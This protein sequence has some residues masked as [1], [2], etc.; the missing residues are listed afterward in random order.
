M[1]PQHRADACPQRSS[2]VHCWR[3]SYATGCPQP[4]RRTVARG[5]GVMV[6]LRDTDDALID[7]EVVER[8]LGEM[9]GA[10]A[11]ALAAASK[12]FLSGDRAVA[13]EIVAG[14]QH[15]D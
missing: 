10:V 1:A 13:R 5:G 7:V 8:L 12:A 15:I 3:P 6:L 14:D 9:F 2:V 11:D 4:E